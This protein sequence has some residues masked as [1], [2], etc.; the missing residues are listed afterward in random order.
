MT[1]LKAAATK[2]VDTATD[3]LALPIFEG[4]AP[5]P[6]VAEAGSRLGTNLAQLFSKEGLKGKIGDALKV[7]TLGKLPAGTVLLVGAGPK[8]TSSEINTIRRVAFV[9]G[10]NSGGY[11]RAASTIAQLG[12]KPAAAD[13]AAA[14]AEGFL[15]GSYNFSV[16]KSKPDKMRTPPKE[17]IALVESSGAVKRAA[18]GL[19]RGRIYGEAANWTRDQVNTPSADFPPAALADAAKAIAK[20]HG[21]ECRIWNAAA[22]KKDGFGGILGVGAG[23]VHNDPRF[24]ELI[25]RGDGNAKPYAI[26]GKGVTFDS[27]GMDIKPAQHMEAMKDDMTGAAA[28]IAVMRAIAQLGLKINVI[29][30]I[31]SAE[32]MPGA[33]ATKPGDVLKHFGGKTS[34]M[35]DT[36]AEG[37]VLLADA[38]AYLAAK[39]PRVII[40]SATLTSTRVGEDLWA[41]IASD[42]QLYDDVAKAGDDV[43]EPGWQLPLWPGY[44]RHTE[45]DVADVKNA[46]WEGPDTL[47]AALFLQEFTDGVPWLH[48][49][50]GDCAT[51][52][53]DRDE[54][55]V[56]P[57]G[58]PS[59]VILR[60]LENQARR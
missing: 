60:Y 23:S 44:K 47:S 32:N 16:Y 19:E 51:L 49:D 2:P 12:A 21:L 40:D 45:S 13:A 34:E 30:G 18:A 4:G 55:P 6:G 52:E 17:V 8:K 43:G 25:Y 59:R 50:V 42:Q 35:T 20:K 7:Q 29:A 22:M 54:W 41:G 39:K 15:L 5:G 48:M 37:R 38:L 11:G 27:G 24:I 10:K 14:F 3:V 56:G 1:K 46:A 57:T 36:D 58:T 9:A 26:T 33:S 31:G 53:F 28:T